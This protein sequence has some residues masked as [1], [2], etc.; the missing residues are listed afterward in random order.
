MGK[1][2][3][4][5]ADASMIKNVKD[6]CKHKF[7]DPSL[8]KMFC[9][10]LIMARLYRN[11]FWPAE[12]G[13]WETDIA[14]EVGRTGLSAIL[15]A[16][17]NGCYVKVHF[18]KNLS[19]NK[20]KILDAANS[21]PENLKKSLLVGQASNLIASAVPAKSQFELSDGTKCFY[22]DSPFSLEAVMTD[23]IFDTAERGTVAEPQVFVAVDCEG[24]PESLELIQIANESSVY[25]IDC[26]ILG[27]ENV[28]QRLEP[29]LRS[30]AIIKMMHDLHKDALALDRLGSVKLE[31]V[32]DTQLL[33]EHLWG[34]FHL[35]FNGLLS[36][37][38]R[39]NHPSK[40]FVHARMRTGV[41]LF[42][43]RP[44][45]QNYLEYAAMDVSYLLAAKDAMLKLICNQELEALIQASSQRASNAAEYNGMRSFCFD[46]ANDHELA[47]A[48]LVRTMRIE[49]GFYGER[50]V[51]ES[52][53]EEVIDSIPPHLRTK[54]VASN[55]TKQKGGSIFS[56]F[57]PD[58]A[59]PSKEKSGTLLPFDKLSDIV[60]DVGRR[61]QCWIDDRRVPL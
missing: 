26:Q 53:V 6:D 38:E 8:A 4:Q 1:A 12:R 14:E 50:L 16:L 45:P 58:K 34:E 24:V 46:L 29:F 27:T 25:L 15:F 39:A 55:A 33:A 10:I 7:D 51:V 42:S 60:L 2:K 36:K 19:W 56:I 30:S 32:L 57:N 17:R 37:L 23:S 3:K 44:I 11:R 18:G 54:F 21:M 59:A 22:I 48:E 47:S 9:A 40:D 49:D 13:D 52:N 35:G 28:C 41:D 31:G 43:E 20:D 5:D 61:P